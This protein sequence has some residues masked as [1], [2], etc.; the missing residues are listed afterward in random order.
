[1][2][3]YPFHSCCKQTALKAYKKGIFSFIGCDFCKT[4]FSITDDLAFFIDQVIAYYRLKTALL[5]IVTC[6]SLMAT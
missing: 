5:S 2:K 1:M 3:M 4:V 6:F